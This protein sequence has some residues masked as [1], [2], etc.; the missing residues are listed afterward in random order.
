MQTIRTSRRARRLLAA[1]ALALGLAAGTLAQAQSA[2]QI[3]WWSTDGGAGTL[4]GGAGTHWVTLDGTLGQA[5]AGVLNGGAGT[6]WVA[7]QGGFWNAALTPRF[8]THLPL[9]IR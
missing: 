8:V 6:H 9:V 1:L 7:L 2:F 3:D 4:S 5:D